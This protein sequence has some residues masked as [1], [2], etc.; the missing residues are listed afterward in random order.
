MECVLGDV[1]ATPKPQVQLSEIGSI[2]YQN[3]ENIPIHFPFVESGEFVVMPNHMHGIVVIDRPDND[4]NS[5]VRYVP[6]G[7][8]RA[9]TAS[10]IHAFDRGDMV[11]TPNLGVTQSMRLR[12]GTVPYIRT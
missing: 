8:L 7:R 12:R 5:W 1:I 2:V 6:P 10:D 3:W 11:E 4:G 9:V